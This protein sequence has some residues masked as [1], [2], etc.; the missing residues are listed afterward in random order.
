MPV[1]TVEMG[2]AINCCLEYEKLLTQLAET[3]ILDGKSQTHNIVEMQILS[4][5]YQE[6][7][8]DLEFLQE[9]RGHLE[10]AIA[11]RLGLIENATEKESDEDD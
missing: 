1:T 4:R 9:S 3:I 5:L 8:E 7:I 2:K 10:D 6:V 11:L